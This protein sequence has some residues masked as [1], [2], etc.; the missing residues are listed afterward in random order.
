M[1]VPLGKRIKRSVRSAIVLAAIRLLSLLPLG[2]AL[3]LGGAVG[4]MAYLLAGKTRRL[5]LGSRAVAFPERSEVTEIP[6]DSAAPD[7]EAEALRLTSACSLELEPAIRRSPEEWVWVH[8]RWK[9]R[10]PV[11]ASTSQQAST[12]PKTAELSDA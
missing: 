4:R 6:F 10:L 7:R 2:A 12:M 9:T 8:Q 1:T 11:E 5:A 3:A